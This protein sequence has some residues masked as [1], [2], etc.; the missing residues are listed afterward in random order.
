MGSIEKPI[1][2]DDVADIYDYYVTTDLDIPFYLEEFRKREGEVLELMCGTGRVSL[3]L[4][5]QGNS[6]TC[7]D[8]SARMLDKFQEKLVDNNLQARLVEADICHVDLGKRFNNIFIPFNSFMELSGERKQMVALERIHDHLTD[9]GT[10][11]CTLHNPAQRTRLATG[12]KIL[13]GKFPLPD[14]QILQLHSEEHIDSDHGLITGTQYY[15]IYDKH[16]ELLVERQ[17]D[18]S[19]NLLEREQFEHLIKRAGFN[20]HKLYGDYN[21]GKFDPQMSPFMIYCLRK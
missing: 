1:V 8:Y 12:E 19:F 4:I 16:G 6:L 9:N 2:F 17:L 20:V 21:R 14:Y 15:T 11:I 10:F 13:R 18:I 3:P 5:K 7:V